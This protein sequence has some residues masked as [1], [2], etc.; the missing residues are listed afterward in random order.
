MAG[1]HVARLA[2]ISSY[3]FLVSASRQIPHPNCRPAEF[4]HHLRQA[5]VGSRSAFVLWHFKKVQQRLTADALQPMVAG[6]EAIPMFT[7]L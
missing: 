4:S 5:L 2:A 6:S 1:L 3:L 7:P